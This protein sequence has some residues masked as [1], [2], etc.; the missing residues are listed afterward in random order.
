M[1]IS[2]A[3]TI[4]EDLIIGMDGLRTRSLG[5]ILYNTIALAA[6]MPDHTVAPVAYCG[7]DSESELYTVLSGLENLDVSG[8][9]FREG[10][11]NRNTLRYV[12]RNT[13]VE[14]LEA[15]VPAMNLKM[16][17]PCLDSD[18]VHFNFTMGSEIDLEAALGFR[19][20]FSGAI[21]MDVHSMTL[22]VD[23]GRKRFERQVENWREWAELSDAIQMNLRE[24]ELFVGRKNTMEETSS[25]ICNAG[26]QIC[27]I[28][29]GPRG[30]LAAERTQ[31]GVEHIAMDAAEAE[32]KDTTGC[33]DVFSAGFISRWALGAGLRDSCVAANRAA[34]VCCGCAGLEEL[35]E[36]FFS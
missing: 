22:G 1:K 25:L 31:K 18:L 35:K 4:N 20:S 3:G 32:V 10:R 12:S 30:V 2:V 17:H 24:A 26:P 29:L 13:R 8:L 15:S 27:L 14:T 5:G 33:G 19:R 36:A 7:T 21:F 16:L 34:A 9:V 11:C 28:T 23:K 6:L